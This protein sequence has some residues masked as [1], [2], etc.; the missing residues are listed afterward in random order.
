MKKVWFSVAAVVVVLILFALLR[1]AASQAV[2][3]DVIGMPVVTGDFQ[4]AEGPR[5]FSFPL[6]HGPHPDFQTEWWYYTGN[7]RTEDGRPLGYQLTFFRRAIVS[8]AERAPRPSTWATEQVY[9]AHFAV[10]EIDRNQF[11]Y[12]ERLERGAAGLAGARGEPLYSVWLA[13]WSVEQV[14]TNQY[15]LQ[16]AQEGVT[17]DLWLNDY[18]G[19]VLQGEQGYS[20]K[21]PEPG[22]ASYYVS[23]P[24]LET[25]GTVTLE[26]QSQRVDGLSWMD[27]EFSTS[28]LAPD[29]VGWDWF[30]LQLEDG[31]ALMVYTL[32]RSDGRLDSYSQG[33]VIYADGRTRRLTQE[34]FQVEVTRQWRS[35]HSGGVYPAGWVVQVP[36]EGL[37]LRIRPRVADQELNASFIYWEGAV[38]VEGSRDGEVVSGAG[39]VEL[40]GYAQSMQGQF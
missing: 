14:S 1:P 27:H 39:Y 34:D 36:S 33:T 17:L 22:N 3:A 26:G 31:S 15:H 37:T 18:Q 11:R 2:R 21:G 5:D 24:R 6:D 28:A 40:T 4:R 12:S 29:Q 9:M 35:P 10:S 25:S 32:Q 23:Q 16:A 38:S 20:A 30:A 7:L 19:P 13:D 8:P